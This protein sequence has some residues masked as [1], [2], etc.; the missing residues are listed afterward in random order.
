MIDKPSIQSR[1]FH[2]MSRENLLSDTEEC[3]EGALLC[4]R[5]WAG[6][7]VESFGM[8]I[9]LIAREKPS[10]FNRCLVLVR[11]RSQLSAPSFLLLLSAFL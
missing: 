11:E 6:D 1:Q 4:R 7:V 2:E 5:V 9:S 3:G 10:E 8:E